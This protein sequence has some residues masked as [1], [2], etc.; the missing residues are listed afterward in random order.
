M[1]LDTNALLLPFR[2][3]LPLAAEVE[4]CCPGAEV[5]VPVSVL[6]E[7]DRLA[8]R[9]VRLAGPARALARTFRVLPTRARGDA[10]IVAVALAENAG[11]VTADRALARRLVA[12]GISVLLP[13]DRARLELRAGRAVPRGT[14]ERPGAATVKKRA[15]LEKQRTPDARRRPP[16]RPS[17][18]GVRER[19]HR[20]V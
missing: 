15:R 12:E 13:R 20:S 10:A 5:G 11:V 14:A 6:G 18:A 2:T 3:A 17:G 9:G 4:R 16:A 19:R 7:L 8:A 1:I